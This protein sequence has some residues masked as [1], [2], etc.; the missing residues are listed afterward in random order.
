MDNL[1]NRYDE[2]SIETLGAT[3]LSEASIARSAFNVM[4]PTIDYA[5]LHNYNSKLVSASGNVLTKTWDAIIKFLKNIVTK[6]NNVWFDR[7]KFVKTNEKII[8]NGYD[9]LMGDR[10]VSSRLEPIFIVNKAQIKELRELRNHVM[11]QIDS[12]FSIGSRLPQNFQNTASLRIRFMDITRRINENQTAVEVQ[13]WIDFIDHIKRYYRT[14]LA[15]IENGQ[16][17]VMNRYKYIRHDIETGDR[18]ILALPKAKQPVVDKTVTL[19]RARLS[20]VMDIYSAEL[21]ALEKMYVNMYK[22]LRV[23]YQYGK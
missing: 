4:A 18:V 15:D 1:F 21:E 14:D 3:I 10:D 7:A 13:D 8:V 9:L 12:K 19:V 20:L 6:I 22:A 5:A 2:T 17:D 11:K 16:K 23:F